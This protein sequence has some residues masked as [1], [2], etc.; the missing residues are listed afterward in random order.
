[1]PNNIFSLIP[2]SFTKHAQKSDWKW[3]ITK[4]GQVW[5]SQ[6]R[7]NLMLSKILL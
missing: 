2:Q 3:D 4:T 7:I 5:E 1:M 6:R